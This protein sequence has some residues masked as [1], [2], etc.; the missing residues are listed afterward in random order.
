[1]DSQNEGS[2]NGEVRYHGLTV[3]QWPLSTSLPRL[4]RI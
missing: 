3:L 1:M 2:E 4:S